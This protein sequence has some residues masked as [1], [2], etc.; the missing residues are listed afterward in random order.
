MYVHFYKRV[1]SSVKL[2]FDQNWIGIDF[3]L[4]Y[5]FTSMYKLHVEVLIDVYMFLYHDILK[6]SQEHM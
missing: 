6:Y 4:R 3:L 2:S 1:F 5:E